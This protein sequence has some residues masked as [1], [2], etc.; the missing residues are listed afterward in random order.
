[1]HVPT[2][3][4]VL[5]ALTLTSCAMPSVDS[6][7]PRGVDVWASGGRTAYNDSGLKG[8]GRNWEVGASVHFEITYTDEY[9]PADDE[10]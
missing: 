6:F 1:M 5:L 7:R 9:E 10:E 3:L 4:A 2:L 8:K